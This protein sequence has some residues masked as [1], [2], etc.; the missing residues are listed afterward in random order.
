MALS[1]RASGEPLPRMTWRVDGHVISE[2]EEGLAIVEMADGGGSLESTLQIH[3][4]QPQHGG[5]YY[6]VAENEVGRDTADT[7][8][9]VEG[10][11]NFSD[12][13]FSSRCVI[14]YYS[15]IW[16]VLSFKV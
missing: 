9:F 2:K 3:N 12:Y 1:C 4:A 11:F 13:L 10:E 6:C 14:C 5:E 16:F 15:Y 8:I 7:A